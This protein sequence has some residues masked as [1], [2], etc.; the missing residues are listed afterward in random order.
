[1]DRF[2]QNKIAVGIWRRYEAATFYEHYNEILNFDNSHLSN[3]IAESFN[4][5]IILFRSDLRQIAN[6]KFFLFRVANL[7]A[8]LH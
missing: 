5:K 4:A 8:F 6:K 3:T 2:C 1:M 7:Y